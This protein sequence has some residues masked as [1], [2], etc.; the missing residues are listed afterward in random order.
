MENALLD[1][2]TIFYISKFTDY[3]TTKNLNLLCKDVNEVIKP[4][5]DQIKSYYRTINRTYK[6]FLYSEMKCKNIKDG[7]LYIYIPPADMCPHKKPQTKYY[8]LIDYFYFHGE[9]INNLYLRWEANNK[10]F[11]TNAQESY[12]EFDTCPNCQ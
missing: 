2:D 9:T 5:I 4:Q 10:D 8:F 6:I 1:F 3:E 7:V 11:I 12:K